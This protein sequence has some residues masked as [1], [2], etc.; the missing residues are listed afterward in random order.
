MIAT[1]ALAFVR[2][3]LLAAGL[4]LGASA[5]ALAQNSEGTYQVRF[6]VFGQLG[7]TQMHGDSPTA[8]GRGLTGPF[9]S[10]RGLCAK[11]SCGSN[12]RG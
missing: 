1:Y 8:S 4:A 5:P 10:T 7:S 3:G 2:T 6:G 11:A 9:T 12:N